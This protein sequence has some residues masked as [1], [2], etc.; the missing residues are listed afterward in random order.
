MNKPLNKPKKYRCMRKFLHEFKGPMLSLLMLLTI[1]SGLVQAQGRIVSGNV[2]DSKGEAIPGVN[3]QVKGTSNG[4]ISGS[5]G[6]FQ[7]SVES[8]NDIL[9][10][11]F[12]GFEKQEIQVGSKTTIDV[13]LAD[14]VSELDEIVV[15]GY[16][17]QKKSVVTGAITKV[18]GESLNNVPNGRIET[19]L[20]GRVAGVTISQNS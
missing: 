6:D 19:A 18:S 16:G 17:E 7:L 10:F 20:Q 15:V 14:D 13:V 11:S 3:I 8:D 4:T 9:V 12:V 2:K 5:T 1:A